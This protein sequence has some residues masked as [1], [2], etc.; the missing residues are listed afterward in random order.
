MTK[1]Q[2]FLIL[3]IASSIMFLLIGSRDGNPFAS[4]V[5]PIAIFVTLSS[6]ANRFIPLKVWEKFASTT[7]H[8]TGR[9]IF[10]LRKRTKTKT[11]A[12]ALLPPSSSSKL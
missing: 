6:F 5:I 3:A 7:N 2:F 9:K 12:Q 4:S 11:K 10:W 1:F 8:L